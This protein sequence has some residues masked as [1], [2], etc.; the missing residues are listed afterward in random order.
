[1]TLAVVAILLWRLDAMARETLARQILV[2][3]E[4]A[5]QRFG[6][7][8]VDHADIL[9]P[10]RAFTG[11]LQAGSAT[12]RE[13]QAVWDG[14]MDGA[15]FRMVPFLGFE[16]RFLAG[17]G[18]PDVDDGDA[19]KT[20]YGFLHA[21][22]GDQVDALTLQSLQDLILEDED[23]VW[24]LKRSMDSADLRMTLLLMADAARGVELE[25]IPPDALDLRAAIEAV[26]RDAR[27]GGTERTQVQTDR[28]DNPSN[29][30]R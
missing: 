5:L 22:R 23:G 2:T 7:R 24:R 27:A 19:Q 3:T 6:I 16:A 10:L 18:L 30:R 4:T 17:D 11:E 20:L 25:D 15:F 28:E 8:E 13:A 12:L 14:L 9:Q 26:I 29:G 1:M 21:L